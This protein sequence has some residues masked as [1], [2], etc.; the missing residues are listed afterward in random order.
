MSIEQATAFIED[1]LKNPGMRENIET[2]M[3]IEERL[4]LA[5]SIGYG[6]SIDDFR[7][8]AAAFNA[9]FHTR[10]ILDSGCR[11]VTAESGGNYCGIYNTPAPIEKQH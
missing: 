5:K 3:T 6:F 8:V 2:C 10:A 1:I 4:S 7:E 11:V 9:D